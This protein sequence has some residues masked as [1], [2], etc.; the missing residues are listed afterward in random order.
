LR[1]LFTWIHLSDVQLGH[2]DAGHAADQR[3][4]LA[5]LR[6]DIP[7]VLVGANLRP[8][9]I[10]VTG[11][12]A[13]AG[14]AE[15]YIEARAWLDEV[16]KAVGVEASRIYVVPGNHDVD[17]DLTDRDA[18]RLVRALRN[19]DELLDEALVE[20]SRHLTRRQQPYL[21][22]AAGLAPAC[23][24]L[25]WV[26]HLDAHDGLRVRLAGL[27]RA[28]LS[29][30]KDDHGKL[31]LGKAQIAAAIERNE[32]E[33][34]LVLSHHPFSD[35]WLADQVDADRWIRNGAHLHLFGHVK[36][37]GS[38]RTRTGAG[39]DFVSIAARA[40]HCNADE[41]ADHGYSVGSV[42]R[43][44]DGSIAVRVWPRKWSDE[45]K[46]LRPDVDN[47]DEG[48]LYVEHQLRFHLAGPPV[49]ASAPAPAPVVSIARLPATSRELFGR[50]TE[51]AWLDGC[52]KD[53]VCVASVVAFGGV[54]KSALVNAWLREMAR[55]GWRG[56]K[57][58][59]GWSFYDQGTDRLSSSDEFFA[60]ALK[61]FGDPNPTEG[62]PWDKGER[63]AKL[64]R[65]KRTLL[66]LDGL[67]PLQWGP[68]VQQG[69]L[70]DP[71]LEALVKELV[72]QNNGLCLVTSR[73]AL[74][75]LEGLTGDRVRAQDLAHL[76]PKA[77]AELL[78]ARGAKGTD[79]ELLEATKEY[80]GHGLALRLLGSYLEDVA[81]GDIR[82]RKE[83]GPLAK[84][85]RQGGHAR[86]VMA[87]Y[88]R[89][90]GK[91]EV[92]ILH[93]LGLFDRPVDEDEIAALRV[94][95]MVSGLTDALA[96][97][98]GREWKKAVG[99]LRRVGL[100]AAE[101]DKRLDAHPLVREHFGEQLKREQ[102]EAW[103]EGHRRLYEH[104]KKKAKPLPETIEEM[105]PLYAAVVHG[106]MAGKNQ[107]VLNDV[108]WKRVR[109]EKNGFS[110]KHLGA[111]S[112]EVVAISA[113]FDAAG[114]KL[115][116]GLSKSEEALVLHQAGIV[117][118]ALGRLPRA[119]GLMRRGLKRYIAEDDSKNAAMVAANISELLQASGEL[120]GALSKAREGVKFADK[121]RDAGRGKINR[122]ALGAVLHA[123]GS[124]EDAT[125]QFEEAERMQKK[126]RDPAIPMLCQL[127]GFRYCDTLL[128]LGRDE[129]VLNRSVQT[130]EW[131]KSWYP[132]LDFALDHVSVG[133]AH[134]LAAQRRATGD[135][136][137]AASHLWQ[138]VDNFRRAGYQEHIPLGL[139][140][141]A[142]L[143][144]H[145]RTFPAARR[146]LDEAL[147]L[148]TRCGFRLHEADAHLGHA[149]LALA[150]G[151]PL[152]AREHLARATKI[153]EATGYHRRDSE[154]AVLESALA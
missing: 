33:L 79:E 25:F 78:K 23:G 22:F 109:R 105:S 132:V 82:R 45:N 108:F 154:L 123:M 101:Q 152:V 112:S 56:S 29:A 84:D 133:R 14:K 119:A 49:P 50:E 104:L 138:A 67:E 131:G 100:L 2:G 5:A 73:I 70:K 91:P 121:S 46:D 36:G 117:Y 114:N 102:P 34:V 130:L 99:N 38:H 66:I 53:S 64:I 28:L 20:D 75:D 71:A 95:P 4:V 6:K 77:G 80:K 51:L 97:I 139:L 111:F 148:A 30:E 81:E 145:T 137:Q 140:A 18:A 65:G 94:E 9:V 47:L 43:G 55:D 92:A 150:E 54:G 118:R 69:K 135:L 58:V 126:E 147:T 86:R 127:W 7:R 27:N 3:M 8:D 12:I 62:S 124:W 32:G 93:M 26:D 141:R 115:T 143:H 11:N 149:R 37:A 17:H 60:D 44:R 116:S 103:R 76:S 85:E 153:V 120:T 1:P 72:G 89:W 128:D 125:A 146:D 57:R 39:G 107:E 42:V 122:T 61:S 113:F 10:L 87:A 151:N 16:A 74:T 24:E 59:Y 21:N 96:V 52:W 83:I 48:A 144:T 90:L 98:S 40:V 35:G 136:S 88:E 31:C 110:L 19:G 142:A 129:E 15:Q 68:G 106:C 13:W 63:L 41:Q 134:L